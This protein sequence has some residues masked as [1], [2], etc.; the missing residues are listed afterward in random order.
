MRVTIFSHESDLDGIYSAAIGLIRF[1]QARTFFMGY[2]KEDFIKMSSQ[3]VLDNT[4]EKKLFIISDLGLNSSLLDILKSTFKEIK[5]KNGEV[6]WLDH[7]PWE[8]EKKEELSQIITLVLDNSN[9]KCAAELVYEKFLYGNKLAFNLSSLAHSMDFFKKDQYLTPISE[10]IKYYHTF[11]NK[12]NKLSQLAYKSSKGILWDME[13]NDEYRTYERLRDKDKVNAVKRMV[14]KKILDI[15]VTF[16]EST[17]Y[18]QNSLFAEEIFS[19]TDS[20]IIIF[21]GNDKKVSIRRNNDEISCKKIALNLID[22][23]GHEF[24]AGGYYNSDP[25]EKDKIILELENAIKKSIE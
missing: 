15:N 16:C 21:Y 3:I 1:P 4:N 19:K 5:K 2:S 22:G 9:T 7:H 23:G 17:Q 14:T 11:P 20:D 10:I 18:L 25:N 24:A 13:M 8:Q 6:I 12:Y